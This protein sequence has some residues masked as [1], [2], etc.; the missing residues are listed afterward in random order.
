MNGHRSILVM[1]VEKASRA[2]HRA[3]NE[4]REYLLPEITKLSDN[5]D[6]DG[7]TAMMDS[8]PECYVKFFIF[9]EIE[10]MS[11]KTN[12]MGDTKQPPQ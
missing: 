5:K 10:R 12:E 8:L 11:E 3:N 2:L 7:L 1:E 9:Q 4:L 6:I